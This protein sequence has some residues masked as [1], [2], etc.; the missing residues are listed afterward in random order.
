MAGRLLPPSQPLQRLDKVPRQLTFQLHRLLRGRVDEAQPFGVQALT[1]KA[2]HR[3]FGAVNG[4]SQDRV[5][6]L[7]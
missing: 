7:I 3:L 4:V 2:G 5:W 6:T 1:L